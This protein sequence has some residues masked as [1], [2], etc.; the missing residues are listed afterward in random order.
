MGW[1]EEEANKIEK[2]REMGVQGL[3]GVP[4]NTLLLHSKQRTESGVTG[5]P[6]MRAADA[7]KGT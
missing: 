4:W 7:S 6:L 1:L 2:I 3:W 5:P